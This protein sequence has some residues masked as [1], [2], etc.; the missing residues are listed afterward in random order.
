MNKKYNSVIEM[1]EGISDSKEFTEELRN[2]LEST[3][4]ARVLMV[5]RNKRG[6]TQADVAKKMGYRQSKISK[7]EHTGADSISVGDLRRYAEALGVNITISFH[8]PMNAVQWIK[9]HAFQIQKHFDDLVELSHKDEGILH[10]VKNFFAESIF[11]IVRLIMDSAEKLPMQ[12]AEEPFAIE[13]ASPPID[14][15]Q[16][17]TTSEEDSNWVAGTTRNR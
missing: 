14:E 6:L 7:L 5:M 17:S 4:L 1:S 15:A 16:P 2:A 13:V 3:K 8:E 12:S 10:G 9:H 11:N